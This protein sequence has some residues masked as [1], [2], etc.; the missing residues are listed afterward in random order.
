MKLYPFQEKVLENTQNFNRVAYYLDMGLG[1]TFVG[2]EKLIQIKNKVNL[3]ICQKSKIDD[4]IKHFIDNYPTNFIFNLTIKKQF[5]C[6]VSTVTT[7]ENLCTAFI[8][9]INYELAFRKPELLKLDNFTLMLDESSMIQN[10]SAKRTKFIQKLNCKNVILLSGTPVSGKYENLYSQCKLLGWNISKEL[11]YKQYMITEWQEFN[12]FKHQVVI[13]Y[14]N[15]DRLKEKLKEHGAVFMKSS[16]A[17]LD[18]PEKN[19]IQINIKTIPEYKKFQKNGIVSIADTELVGDTGLTKLLYARQLCG[20]YNKHKLEALKTLLQSTEDR[21]II[22][23][24]FYE[25]LYK[26]EDVCIELNKPTSIVNGNENDLRGFENFNNSVT[27]I[28]YQSGAMGL[29]LQKANKTVYFTLPLSSELFEQSKSRTCR[30]GQDRPCFYY[31]LLCENSI[32]LNILQT[33]RMRKD[34]TDYLFF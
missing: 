9:I 23:Y 28:Q 15:V 17:N 14:K 4:W 30:I 20:H 32:E 7:K 8:G 26:I 1:K 25:E 22:F 27:L 5:E 12:G 3:V 6:F 33:L 24:N 16:E 11:F 2:S 19:D 21:V 34:Y 31:Y 18:L 29:N 10:T 13:G